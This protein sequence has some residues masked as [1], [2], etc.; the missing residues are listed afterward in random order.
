VQTEEEP[1]VALEAVRIAALRAGAI[2]DR[3]RDWLETLAARRHEPGVADS[4]TKLYTHLYASGVVTSADLEKWDIPIPSLSGPFYKNRHRLEPSSNEIVALCTQ[5]GEHPLLSQL[6]YP[7]TLVFG[8]RVKGYGLRDADCDIAVFVRP[9]VDRSKREYLEHELLQIF[10]HKRFDGGIKLFWLSRTRTGLEVIDWPGYTPSDA[11]S[12]WIYALF[13]A[14]WFGE[15]G[16]IRLLHEQLLTSYF[17]P[18]DTFEDGKPTYERWLEEMERDSLQYRLMHKGFE[19]F[20]P[21]QSP[22]HTEHGALIDGQSA[23]Y[24]P[25]YRRIAT[26]LFLRRVFLP[27]LN[28]YTS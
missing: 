27:N 3:H 5:V 2:F 12:G 8:S 20:Y 4:L 28:A 22:M 11:R 21:V 6:V 1:L 26:E 19:R 24:D 17:R 14:L 23:F 16:S 13:G 7:V 18:P 9:G 10:N 15:E 25:R